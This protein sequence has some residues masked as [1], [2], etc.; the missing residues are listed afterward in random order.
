MAR[1]N[2]Q[3]GSEKPEEPISTPARFTKQQLMESELYRYSRD[4]LSAILE[5]DQTY[6]RLEVEERITAFQKGRVN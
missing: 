4:L 2:R 5:D 6:T 1:N 3:P